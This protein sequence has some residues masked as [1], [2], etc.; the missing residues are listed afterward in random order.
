VPAVAL[1]AAQLG[2]AL[3]LAGAV[4]VAFVVA[5]SLLQGVDLDLSR[6]ALEWL[7]PRLP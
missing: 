1:G 5:W 2:Q 7:M 4:V 6:S 3:A